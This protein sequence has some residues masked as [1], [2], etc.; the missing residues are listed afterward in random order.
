M[1]VTV[2]LNIS[3]NT[4]IVKST[5]LPGNLRFANWKAHIDERNICPAVPATVITMVFDKYLV[6][7]TVLPKAKLNKS[8][9]LSVVALIGKSL[10][11]KSHNSLSGLKALPN[12]SISGNTINAAT[13][14]INTINAIVPERERFFL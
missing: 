7:G 10:G 2:A 8:V 14:R 9:K 1:L 3:D 4:I 12:M 11:G 5:L 6:S 13:A